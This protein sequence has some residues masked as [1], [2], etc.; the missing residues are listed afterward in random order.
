MDRRVDGWTGGPAGVLR[1]DSF[2]VH[3]LLPAPRGSSAPVSP[4]SLGSRGPGGVGGLR[5]SNEALMTRPK[6][7]PKG[8]RVYRSLW[9]RRGSEMKG[10]NG[11]RTGPTDRVSVDVPT[12]QGTVDAPRDLSGPSPEPSQNTSCVTVLR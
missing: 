7:G 10:C 11:P 2:S 4:R 1:Y 3:P 9:A 12:S 5:R 8:C 6:R